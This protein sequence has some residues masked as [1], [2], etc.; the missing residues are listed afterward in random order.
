MKELVGDDALSPGSYAAAEAYFGSV[1][2]LQ[3]ASAVAATHAD[4]EMPHIALVRNLGKEAPLGVRRELTNLHQHLAVYG[5]CSRAVHHDV[6]GLAVG[7][8]RV[9]VELS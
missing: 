1:Q 2:V 5:G 9:L 3:S 8:V 7:H 4:V 6:V